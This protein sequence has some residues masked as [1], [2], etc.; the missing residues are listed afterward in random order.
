MYKQRV[1]I[2]AGVTRHYTLATRL[3]GLAPT[4][5]LDF[6]SG[7]LDSRV[8][9]SRGTQATLVDSTGKV[10]YAPN[11]VLLRSEEFN[12][13]AWVVA[14]AS[15]T[16]DNVTAPN[17]TLTADTLTETATTAIHNIS[18][19][20]ASVAAVA[21][22]FSVYLKKGGGATAPDWMQLTFGG[23]STAYVNFNLSSGVVG[24]TSG[25]SATISSVG[26]GWFRCSVTVTPTAGAMSVQIVF[27]NNT[28]S[29]TRR[30]SYAGQT[31][32]N[33]FIWGA[34]LEAV[35][36]QT[37][38]STYVATTTAAYYGPRFDY[39]PVTLNAKGLLDELVHAL[40]GV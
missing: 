40:R 25:A 39:D 22:T 17:G 24:V 35:T 27:T 14:D 16:A 3:G 29:A 4:L 30:P 13:A 18:Q 36:Y 19:T 21:H 23:A 7:S 9:F 26:S 5:T 31:S 34:Q 32:S 11:N 33:V 8:T 15:I 37:T 20:L 38:P 28:D 12:N 6:L 10:T 2:N 1:G